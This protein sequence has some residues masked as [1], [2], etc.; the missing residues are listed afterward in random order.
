MATSP[1]PAAPF[2][3]PPLGSSHYAVLQLSRAASPQELRQAFRHLSKLYHPDTTPLPPQEAEAAFGRLQLAYATL[4]DPTRRRAYDQE[5]ALMAA[6]PLSSVRAPE[7]GAAVGRRVSVRRALS[8]GEWFALLLLGVALILS[9]V[10][11]LGVAWARGTALI[12]PPSWSVDGVD[13]V[14]GAP[15]PL[16]A[17]ALPQT[18][19]AEPPSH[20]D[21]PP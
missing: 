3:D 14:D 7:P 21:A 15:K 13:R 2:P 6:P 18:A 12:T 17:P 9:L 20:A 16:L 19:Q 1:N 4:S 5:L 10:L 8:G 11:G